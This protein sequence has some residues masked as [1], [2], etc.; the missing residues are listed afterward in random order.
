MIVGDCELSPNTSPCPCNPNPV[1][2]ARLTSKNELRLSGAAGVGHPPCPLPVIVSVWLPA[3]IVAPSGRAGHKVK[4]QLPVAPPGTVTANVELV[5]PGGKKVAIP[6]V[7]G[8][9]T[10]TLA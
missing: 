2:G 5:A 8:S 7:H 4:E 9:P 10:T 3:T 1:T 6:L